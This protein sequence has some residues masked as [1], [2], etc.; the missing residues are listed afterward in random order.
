[1]KRLLFSFLLVSSFFHILAEVTIIPN[2]LSYDDVL[3]VPQKSPV[4]SRKNVSMK[5]RLTKNIWLNIPIVSSNMDTVTEADMAIALA[6]LGGIGIIHRF[7]TIQEQVAQVKT[8]K[9]HRNAIIEHPFVIPVDATIAQAHDL[10][11]EHGVKGL[12]VVDQSQK[13][14][15]I[16]TSR[17]IRFC[18][19]ESTPI[20]LLMTPRERLIVGRLGMSIDEAKQLLKEH[21]IEK[22]PLVDE[23]WNITGLITGKDIYTKAENPNASVDGRGRLIVGAAI[24]VQEEELVRAHALIEADVDVLVLDIAHGHSDIALEFI[25]RVKKEFPGVEL[26]A[27][28]VATPQGARAL[29]EAGAD[30]VK[31]GV[32]PGSICTT[33][34]K[35][36]SGYPQFS[37]IIECAQV[38]DLYDVPVI[39]DGGIKVSGDITKAIG[40]GASTVMIGSMFAGTDESPGIPFIKNGKKYKVVRGMASFGANLGRQEKTKNNANPNDFVPEGVEALVPYKGG[41]AETVHQLVGGLASGLS[42]CG[43]SSVLE[44]RGNGIFV[45]ISQAG[46]RESNVHDV[47]AL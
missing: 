46:M 40:A 26:I 28:N 37:A 45:Q 33:R 22:L 30:A 35:T 24:G 27:G 1:M 11:K 38:A 36:G 9:R 25:R 5:T 10:M 17:D 43:V 21:R 3:L 4:R 29:I 6:C 41:V 39:A 18:P 42:Y 47:N 15:G 7:N 14:V 34:I 8:V 12:L 16:L 20:T 31:V 19:P 2:G 13:L 23:A 44:L 32:G